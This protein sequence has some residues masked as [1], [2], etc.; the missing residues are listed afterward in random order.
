MASIEKD[1]F[2]L[3]F[4]CPGGNKCGTTWLSEMLRQHPE[5]NV[6]LNKEPHYF[7]SNYHK[8][9]SW[10][11]KNWEAKPG[12]KGE[13]STSY[14]Y[15]EEAVSRLRLKYPELKIIVCLRNPFERSVSHFRHLLRDKRK[16]TPLTLLKERPEII[17]N[18]FFS[19][20]INVLLNNFPVE[21]I[22]LVYYDQ[23]KEDPNGLLNAVFSFLKVAP[24]IPDNMTK[25][26]GKGF[27]P[28]NKGLEK[29]REN[30]YYFLKRIGLYKL[31]HLIKKTGI[32]ELFKQAN[33]SSIQD[34]EKEVADILI[35]EL[36]RFRD[37]LAQLSA[38]SIIDQ[39]YIIKW[40]KEIQNIERNI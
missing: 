39:K 30:T 32:P 8:G 4:V 5:L 31:I 22:H 23:I 26:I 35:Q 1:D 20:Q 38:L 16:V 36:S 19:N 25:V 24:F 3:D 6:S 9:F 15:S 40:E 7:S 29:V 27:D 28:K 14:L 2:Q 12:L 37:E 17:T 21:Q 18:S 33:S 11:Q 13:F 34:K 10:Y